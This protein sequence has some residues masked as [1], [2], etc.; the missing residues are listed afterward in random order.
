MRLG[1]R[2]KVVGVGRCEEYRS[3]RERERGKNE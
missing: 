3:D 1:W 2:E